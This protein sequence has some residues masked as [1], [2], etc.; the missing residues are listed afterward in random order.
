M[1]ETFITPAFSNKNVIACSS[2]NDYVPYLGVYLLSIIDHA[3][4]AKEYDIVI[5]ETDITNN[6]KKRILEMNTR[7]NISIRFFNVSYLFDEYTLHIEYEYFAKQCYFRLAAGNI[8]KD[9]KLV[10]F[11]D[12]DITLNSDIDDYFSINLE[13]NPLAACK[14]ILWTVENRKDKFQSGKN[15]ENYI[16]DEIKTKEYYNTG[17]LLID[18]KK[19][20]SITSFDKLINI[21]QNN[22]FINQEQDVLNQVFSDKFT[23]LDSTLNYEVI[24]HNWNGISP[25]YEDHTN[26]IND[27][28]LYHFLT[29]KKAWYYPSIL[30]AHL[31]WEYARKTPFYEEILARMAEFRAANSSCTNNEI[32]QLRQEFQDIHFPAINNTFALQKKQTQLLFVMQNI[33]HFRFK[34][35]GY[36]FKKAVA[37]GKKHDKYQRKYHT[38]KTL[39]KEAKQFRKH[40]LKV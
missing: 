31:W 13:N 8:F 21:A 15:I 35:L 40:L 39:L 27:A 28:K 17:V 20:N 10:L 4:D 26:K 12:I 24:D 34:K 33:N 18:V 32:S 19:F 37:F 3:D 38:V 23:T 22:S 5:L 2:S 29:R 6:N 14:E 36:A 1:T 9:Y 11:T 7:K 16:S 25:T 30:K